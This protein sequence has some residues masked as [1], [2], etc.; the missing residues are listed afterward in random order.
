MRTATAAW[1]CLLLPLSVTGGQGE[2]S[3]LPRISGWTLTADSAVYDPTNLWDLIDGAA[4]VFLS[5]QFQE[6]TVG[7][8]ADGKGY[9][10][11]AEIYRHGSPTMA[12]GMYAAER[13]PE[14]E[15]VDLGTEGYVE[16]GVLNFLAGTYYCKLTTDTRGTPGREALTAVGRGVEAALRQERRWPEGIRLLPASGRKERSEGYVAVN[17]LGYPFLSH[18]FTAEYD[19]T[20]RLYAMEQE[21]AARARAL[22]D[23]YAATAPGGEIRPGWRRVDDPNNGTVFLFLRGNTLWVIATASGPQAEGLARA[24]Q[25]LR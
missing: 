14:Y 13:A 16:E 20:A 19:S 15:F 17:V 24:L 4:E 2:R 25:D 10:V 18:A 3:P 6:L 12:F 8:Y 5:Y 23:R 11:R 9:V 1:I 21:D 22:F 7:S